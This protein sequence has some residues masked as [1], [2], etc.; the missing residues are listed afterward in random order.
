MDVWFVGE[1]DGVG[2]D[3]PRGPVVLAGEMDRAE[4]GGGEEPRKADLNPSLGAAM[5]FWVVGMAE[6]EG[7]GGGAAASLL[8]DWRGADLRLGGGSFAGEEESCGGG[9]S[10]SA[11]DVRARESAMSW[12]ESCFDEVRPSFF[13]EDWPW[14]IVVCARRAGGRGGGEW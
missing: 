12:G 14:P 9:A 8:P 7:A 13:A 3:G 1:P 5:M 2:D 6:G 10:L 11:R 4:G